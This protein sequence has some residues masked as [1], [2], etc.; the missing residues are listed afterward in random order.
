MSSEEVIKYAIAQPSV[1]VKRGR[2]NRMITAWSKI[3]S[4]VKH[5]SIKNTPNKQSSRKIYTK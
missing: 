1:T 3:C 4:P 2:S 5:R